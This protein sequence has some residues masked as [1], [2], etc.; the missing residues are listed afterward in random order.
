MASVGMVGLI[1]ISS[2]V[3]SDL[4]VIA[5]LLGV[6]IFLTG[7]P[8]VLRR[9]ELRQLDDSPAGRF[10]STRARPVHEAQ[11]RWISGR[12]FIPIVRAAGVLCIVVALL[13]L[14]EVVAPSR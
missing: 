7:W 10:L 14:L 1:G 5:V 8:H 13:A 4:C 2:A 12:A 9:Y 11:T 3:F 6:G